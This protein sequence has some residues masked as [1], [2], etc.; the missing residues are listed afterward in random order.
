MIRVSTFREVWRRMAVAAGFGCVL[1]AALVLSS[2]TVSAQM[3]NP[4][5]AQPPPGQDINTR[6]RPMYGLTAPS[7]AELLRALQ[8]VQGRVTIPDPKAGVLIQPQG[9]DWRAAIKGPVSV[10]GSWLILG[11]VALLIVFYITR[12]KITVAGGLSGRTIE[13]FNPLDRFTHWVTAGSFVVLALTGLNITYGRYILLPLLGPE[14]FT[15]LTIA[16]KY[17]HNYLAFAFM[18]GLAMMFVLWVRHNF[19]NRYDIEWLMQGGGMFKKGLHPPARKFNA[20]QKILFWLV[21]W[22]GLAISISGVYL[23]F[24]FSFGD[25]GAQQIAQIVHAVV[26]LALIAVVIAHIYIGSIG[27]EGAFAAM[28]TGQVDE[29]WAREHHSVWVAEVKGEAL[30]EGR[31]GHD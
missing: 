9:R 17:A 23:L 30:P 24:P 13:R 5:V 7:E 4:P 18:V 15:A 21:I 29:K 6:E 22:G 31:P 25:I 2:A 14:A 1:A 20:G 26:S 10:L 27:M 8:G 16:G 19:P 3:G 28:E 12:G 11:M